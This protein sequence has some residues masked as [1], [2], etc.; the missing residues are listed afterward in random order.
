MGSIRLKILFILLLLYPFSVPAIPVLD[1]T[2]LHSG[3]NLAFDMNILV[4]QEVST[5]ETEVILH[6]TDWL[7]VN[8]YPKLLE[9]PRKYSIIWLLARVKNSSVDSAQRWLEFSP[10]RLNRIDVW[11]ID[12]VS[13]EV[14][15]YIETG[16]DKP[17]RQRRVSSNR[18]VV[19]INLPIGNTV[20]ILIRIESDSRPYLFIQSWEPVGFAT[21]QIERYQFHSI[22]LAVTL[23]LA[24]V[25]LLQNNVH[26]MLV[27][28]WM[29]SLF[30]FESEKEAYVSYLLFD[31]I[32]Y[33]ARLLRFSSAVFSMSM[34]MIVSVYLLRIGRHWLWRWTLPVSFLFTLGYMGLIFVLEDNVLRKSALAFHIACS[35]IWPFFIPAALNRNHDWQRAILT[36]L[37][38]GWLTN[39]VYMFSYLL[40]IYYTSEMEAIRLVIEIALVLGLLLTY[41]LQKRDYERSLE[42]QLRKNEQADRKRLEQAVAQRTREMNIALDSARKADAA[43]TDFLSRVTHDLKSPLTSIMGYA[44]LLSAEPGKIGQ[45]GHII[46]GSAS[47][48]LSLID[49]LINYARDVTTLG[50]VETDLYLHAFINS[51][52]CEARILAGMRG[53]TFKLDISP[54]LPLVIR[55]DETL[56]REI[57]LNL[58][59]NAAKYNTG[60]S[61]VLR[62]Y[63]AVLSAGT[64]QTLELVCEVED[65]GCGIDPE[66][67]TRLFDPFFRASA[68]GEGD[69]LGLAIVKELV[70]RLGGDVRLKSMP[71]VGTCIGFSIPVGLGRESADFALLKTPSHILP[72][73]DATGLQAWV[74][75]DARPIRELLH[76][77]LSQL[78]FDVRAFSDAE[79][80]INA[81]QSGAVMPDII[82]TDHRLPK[83]SGDRVLEAA[84]V[85][86][87]DLPVL[88]LSATW[89][90]Q[91]NRATETKP[92]YTAMLGKPVDLV[93]LRHEVAKA[94]GLRS[95]LPQAAEVT[96]VVAKP[97][98]P[99][100]LDVQSR[101]QVQ[102][103]LEQGAVTDIVE[104]CE[105][106]GKQCSEYAGLSEELKFLA[107]R[108]DFKAI[109]VRLSVLS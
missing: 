87:P 91:Q 63:S 81:M 94:C 12:S 44:Q 39:A 98:A 56:L 15:D 48:M 11:M 93:C 2:E 60:S 36:L 70:E 109:Q 30:V 28:F 58:L 46:Y 51:V 29:L 17:L 107:E 85:I 33:Y 71:G 68:Q 54:R 99:V 19:P 8:K 89:Y 105:Q 59:E 97:N 80:A 67:Q 101:A 83:A 72:L 52:A 32:P 77:E 104:W 100:V 7:P 1:I 21:D 26:F 31:G 84:R 88:L 82:L 37:G 42:Q 14:I 79:S 25:L 57:L 103:W 35:V 96:A 64:N 75:E 95:P 90:L 22:L 6:S 74:V 20:D 55:C 5:S 40:N 9:S 10:W 108:G 53:N 24:A 43:K 50:I 49:R 69:G 18:A 76:L 61:I 34:F 66:Q 23:T 106:L 27:C 3:A 102:L 38:L 13:G 16:L 86:K 45:K 92:S 65:N 73:Y 47:H 78:G 62:F 4:G 41:T